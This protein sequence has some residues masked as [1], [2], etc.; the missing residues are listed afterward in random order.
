MG[1]VAGVAQNADQHSC[2]LRGSG[3]LLPQSTRRPMSRKQL[4]SA[5]STALATQ[6]FVNMVNAP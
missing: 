6:G 4:H 2:D 1:R 5:A 3:A